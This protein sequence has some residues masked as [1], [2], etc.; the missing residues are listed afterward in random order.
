MNEER[1]PNWAEVCIKITEYASIVAIVY[2]IAKCT[3]SG[4]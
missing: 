3:A 4:V 2:L 1:G